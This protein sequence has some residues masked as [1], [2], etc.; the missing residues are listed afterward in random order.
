[1]HALGVKDMVCKVIVYLWYSP[2]PEVKGSA[3]GWGGGGGKDREGVNEGM[4]VLNRY[5]GK[6]GGVC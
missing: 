1:M 5:C 3:T 6:W 4:W 2:S